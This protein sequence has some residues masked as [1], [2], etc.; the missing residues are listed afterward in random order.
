M[1]RGRRRPPGFIIPA[2]PGADIEAAKRSV[3]R[4]N[5]AQKVTKVEKYAEFYDG[6]SPEVT[7]LKG[8]VNRALLFDG[9]KLNRQRGNSQF[10]IFPFGV[11]DSG[12]WTSPIYENHN[13]R[14]LSL[15]C[16]Y[17]QTSEFNP[18]IQFRVFGYD[19]DTE[20]PVQIFE[21][22]SMEPNG[23]NPYSYRLGPGLPAIPG[24]SAN[25]LIPRFF[26][27]Q[28]FQVYASPGDEYTFGLSGGLLV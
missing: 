7:A 5:D 4:P 13:A 26:L 15:Q 16:F 27:V 17:T 12:T 18:E 6:I 20:Q 25:T 10:T 22:L 1:G 14:Y 23:L 24:I 2:N 19:P 11:F 9:E 21:S 3:L 28:M 8:T